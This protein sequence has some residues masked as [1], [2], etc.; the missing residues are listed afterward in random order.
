MADKKSITTLNLGSQ[1]VG[2]ARFVGAGKGALQLSSYAFT[3]TGGDPNEDSQRGAQVAGA[4]K[5]LTTQLKVSKGSGVRYAISGQ[6]VLSKFVKLPPLNVEKIDELIGFEAQQAIPFPISEVRW[7]YQVLNKDGGIGEVEAVIAAIKNDVVSELNGAVEGAGLVTDGV[8]IA[9][10]A[11]Y[12]AYRFNY[13]DAAQPALIIDIGARTVNLIYVEPSGKLFFR[14]IPNVGGA[15][16]TQSI[17]REF[18]IDFTEAEQ[19]KISSGFVALSGYADDEDPERAALSKVIRNALTRTHGEIVRTTNLYRSQQGGSA[20]EIVYLAGGGAS[21]PYAREFFEEKLNLPVEYFNALRNVAVGGKVSAEQA[22]GDAHSLGEVVGLALRDILACPMEL[23]IVPPSVALRRDN[24]SRKPF[25]FAAAACLLGVFGAGAFYHRSAVSSIQAKT[26]DLEARAGKLGGFDAKIKEQDTRAEKEMARA[27]ILEDAV[28]NRTYWLEVLN[29][30]NNSLD[31]DYIWLTQIEPTVEGAPV[32]EPIFGEQKA[33]TFEPLKKKAA[34]PAPKGK[35]S[36]AAPAPEKLID[37][38]NVF[39]LYRTYQNE[40]GAEVV[41]AFLENLKK[42]PY[43][44]LPADLNLE[45]Y[46]KTEAADETVWASGFE[47]RLPLK[48]KRQAVTKTKP[49]AN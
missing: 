37:G 42:S 4:V 8:D 27:K 28:V 46:L 29:A 7:H 44:E 9:P 39:G 2:M 33:L 15:S 43:F 12:N 1:R 3:E 13:P 30:L 40:K 48:T 6:P 41:T 35:A 32:T 19:R 20:P 47:L 22:Q 25:L 11:L 24:A 49:A 38:I 16:V 10:L 14:S 31:T 26:S 34:A 23:D 17:A 21:L 5:Y 18:Q 45:D 36:A